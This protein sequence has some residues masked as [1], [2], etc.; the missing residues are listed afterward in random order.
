MTPDQIQALVAVAGLVVSGL[1]GGL[2]LLWKVSRYFHT[3]D[4]R[5]DRLASVVVDL[6][7]SQEQAGRDFAAMRVMLQ[8][9]EKD[10][11]RLEGITDATRKDL[12][13]VTGDLRN[14]VDKIEALW[15]TLQQLFPDQVRPRLSDRKR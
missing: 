10:T 4:T 12:M 13:T 14:T 2:A 5:L 15:L 7:K 1:G 11:M 3:N 9:R 6:A 8:E